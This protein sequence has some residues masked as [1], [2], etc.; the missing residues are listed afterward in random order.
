MDTRSQTTKPHRSVHEANHP[1]W[2]YG[3]GAVIWG[4]GGR[5]LAVNL[6]PYASNMCAWLRQES[7]GIWTPGTYIAPELE[8]QR[9]PYTESMVTLAASFASALNDA[10]KLIDSEDDLHTSEV[11]ILRIRLECELTLYAARFSEAT[12]KQMLHCTAFP[13]K[14]YRHAAM[15][16]LLEKDCN[17]CRK[18]GLPIHNFSLIGSLAHQF[19]LC[20]EFEGCAFDHLIIA[21]KRR[22]F[23]AAHSSAQRLKKCEPVESKQALKHAVDEV[24]GAFAHLLSHIAKVEIAMIK[25]IRLRMAY[26]PNMPPIK[27]Y[28]SFLTKTVTDY[29]KDGVYRGFGYRD[30]RAELIRA[31]RN[32]RKS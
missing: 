17:S 12:I 6:A 4:S 28:N 2:E 27:A 18:A 5:P 8:A 19:F 16:Q 21:N 32:V 14:L 24:A 20:H 3:R 25:E 13:P 9:N 26:Y 23:E 11:E 30:A 1:E 22:N 10:C 15:G 7:Q 31:A 29:D